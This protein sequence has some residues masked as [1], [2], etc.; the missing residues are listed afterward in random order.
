MATPTNTYISNDMVG[1]RED[2]SDAIYDISPSET[3]VRAMMRKVSAKNTIHEWQTD[4]LRASAENAHVEGDDTVATASTPTVRLNNQCQIFKE[5]A[6]V[7]GTDA[8][9]NKAGRAKEMRYQIAKRM[10]E[11]A[12][13]EEKAILANQAKVTRSSAVAG[14][15]AGLGSW[16]TTN[17]SVGSGGSDPT[18]DG[19]DA[20]TDGTQAAF[21]QTRFDTVMQAIWEAGGKPDCVVLSSFQMNK[22]LTFTG[23]NNQRNNAGAG[24]VTNNLVFYQTPWGSVDW[25]M[26]REC[27]SRDVFILQKDMWAIA[28]LRPAKN[29]ELAKTGDSEKREIVHEFTIESRNEKASG[30]VFDNTTS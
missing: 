2:L 18:G 16:I 11:L 10:K 12:L 25:V 8:G 5:A 6:T 23:N 9:L 27:R 30:G 24:R 7:S 21:S 28:E 17:T 20:R 15:L 13:D 19:T 4:A 26:S 1:I 29:T 3:P 14:K 22:A